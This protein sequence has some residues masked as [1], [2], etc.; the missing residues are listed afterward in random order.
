[1]NIDLERIAAVQ[2]SVIG[3]VLLAAVVVT[4][5]RS[6]AWVVRR[7]QPL[8][9]WWSAWNARVADRDIAPTAQALQRLGLADLPIQ[10]FRETGRKTAGSVKLRYRL[11]TFAVGLGIGDLLAAVIKTVETQ[12]VQPSLKPSALMVAAVSLPLLMWAA[13]RSKAIAGYRFLLS[14]MAA[15]EACEAVAS[16][17]TSDRHQ[18]LRHL[19]DACS[20]VRRSLLRVHRIANSVG[21]GSP[22]QRN[23][24]HHAALVVAKL[25]LAEAQVDT[26]GDAGL[27]SLAAL[28]AKIG[29]S[30]A[31]GSVSK[32]LPEQRL[33]GTA[34]VAN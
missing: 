28:L 15:I 9:V 23:A 5:Y 11:L 19:D 6:L 18:A 32:L 4:I 34:P 25:Q 20:T 16:A 12:R 13:R 27:R 7:I 17:G 2:R 31:A 24:K 30:F 8:Q 33:R 3:G 26:K 21:R 22:R 29:N 14:I 10:S 1:M